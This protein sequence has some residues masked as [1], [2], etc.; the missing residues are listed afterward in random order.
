MEEY[1]D[2]PAAGSPWRTVGITTA[3][4]IILIILAIFFFI[5]T[6]TAYV[7]TFALLGTG[8]LAAA[9]LVGGYGYRRAYLQ[10]KTG[11]SD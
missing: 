1:A 10:R 4:V 8:A 7:K 5:D 11:K 3:L 6:T 2:Q 9:I